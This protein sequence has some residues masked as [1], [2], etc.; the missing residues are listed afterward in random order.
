MNSPNRW[1]AFVVVAALSRFLPGCVGDRDG[2][3]VPSVTLVCQAP[4]M[5]P[6]E[7]ESLVT[8]P[9]E[10]MI[11]RTEGVR[12]QASASRAGQAI[13]WIEFDGGVDVYDARGRV[14]ERLELGKLPDGLELSLPP[15]SSGEILL[16]ALHAE[17]MPEA[18]ATENKLAAELRDLAE[19]SLRP[20]LLTIPGVSQVT[21][22][23]GACEQ[24]QVIVSP[25]RLAA[26]DVALPELAEAIARANRTADGS[27]AAKDMEVAIRSGGSLQT[28]EDL[29]STVVKTKHGRPVLVKDVACVRV[30]WAPDRADALGAGLSTPPTA[31]RGKRQPA[32]TAAVLLAIQSQADSDKAELSRS[33]DE[34]LHECQKDLPPHVNVDREMDPRLDPLVSQTLQRM[35]RDLPPDVQLIRRSSER[36]GD[37]FVA[38]SRGRIGVKLFGPDL[39]VLRSKAGEIR[40]R[41]EDVSGVVDAQIEPHG[42]VPRLDFQLDPERAAQLGFTA[43]ELKRAVR[44]AI[45]EH[46]VSQVRSGNRTYDVVLKTGEPDADPTLV[47]RT[48][49]RSES[50]ELFALN[51]LVRFQMT[52]G[53][54]AIY[55]ENSQRVVLISCGVKDRDRPDVESG[56]RKA[57]APVQSSLEGGYHVEY[58]SP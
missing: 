28:A 53:P 58:G 49:V 13:L 46:V 54:R 22:T 33:V 34:V 50:G 29:A 35:Q 2:Q 40:R 44:M 14:A 32:A 8:R 41:L 25:E 5:A 27:T 31:P 1:V 20:R 39:A 7:V 48:L 57:L 16:I 30:A 11:A 26:F 56:I 4:G 52:S 23:G 36:L 51:A 17:T 15:P 43:A 6:E 47:G 45:G 10:T 37:F 21:V 38:S 9:L 18:A 42:D 19:V 3:P 24:D 12:R 55:R